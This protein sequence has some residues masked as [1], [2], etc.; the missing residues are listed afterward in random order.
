MFGESTMGLLGHLWAQTSEAQ[1][2]SWSESDRTKDLLHSL[3][4]LV[5]SLSSTGSCSVKPLLQFLRSLEEL[6]GPGL[7]FHLL[8]H[9]LL[10]QL[11]Q[12]RPHRPPGWQLLYPVG[13]LGLVEG[14][15]RRTP[16]CPEA[17]DL[18]VLGLEEAAR[19]EGGRTTMDTALRYRYFLLNFTKQ[20]KQKEGP[21]FSTILR[22]D[23][24]H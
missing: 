5:V 6:L 3:L 14:W 7:T 12:S 15:G 22:I 23:I 8:L 17:S 13:L 2:P 11:T 20:T 21:W 24:R 9:H 10:L 16:G 18:L 4:D 1:F 19:E